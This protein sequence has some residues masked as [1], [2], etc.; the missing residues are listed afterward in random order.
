M[1]SENSLKRP[2]PEIGFYITRSGELLQEIEEIEEYDQT[3][4]EFDVI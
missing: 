2:L 3:T 4:Q 1:S